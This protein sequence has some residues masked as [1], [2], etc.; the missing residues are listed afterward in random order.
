MSE[1]N[2]PAHYAYFI[3]ARPPASQR[4]LTVADCGRTHA[5]RYKAVT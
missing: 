1:A 5:N 3:R 4:L 2:G